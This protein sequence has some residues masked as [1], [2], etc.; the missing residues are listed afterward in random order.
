MRQ[1]VFGAGNNRTKGKYLG[2]IFNI[3][4]LRSIKNNS[5]QKNDWNA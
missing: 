3:K 5:R 1:P 2:V 4:I